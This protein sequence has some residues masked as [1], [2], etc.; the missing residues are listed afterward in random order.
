MEYVFPIEDKD[1][2]ASYVSFRERTTFG[3]Y[4]FSR[5]KIIV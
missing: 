1:I 5:K 4:I 2:P 3:D